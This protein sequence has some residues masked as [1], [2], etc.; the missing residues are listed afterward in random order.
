MN[1]SEIN[2][3]LSGMDP[4]DVAMGAAF[5]GV[6]GTLMAVGA[7]VWFFVS[8]IGYFK[9]FKKASQ[10]GWFAFVMQRKQSN[11]DDYESFNERDA[12]AMREMV[13]GTEKLVLRDEA[14]INTLKSEI[15]A[16]LG[17]RMDADG[18]AKLIQSKMSIFMAEQYG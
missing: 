10:R 5:V 4:A 1:L 8:A 15:N 7:A 18:T 14:V 9:M 12:E 6:V 13:Y 17:G 3:A 11:V 2:A 16:F